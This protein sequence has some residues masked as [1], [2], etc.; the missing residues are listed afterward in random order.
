MGG[1]VLLVSVLCG[2]EFCVDSGGFFV[3]AI[4]WVVVD[5]LWV[6]VCGWWWIFCGCWCVGAGGFCDIKFVWKLKKWLRK[7]EKFVGK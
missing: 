6:L 7:C 2:G 4:V 1:G 5:F 3:G